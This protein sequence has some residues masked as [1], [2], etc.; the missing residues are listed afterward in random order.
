[1]VSPSLAWDAMLKYTGV[2]LNQ[3]VDGDID[4]LLMFEARIR[5]G[6]SYVGKRYAKANNKYMG[7][8]Y[9]PKDP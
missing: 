9:D 3:L 7:D 1:M 2:T 8:K 4:M 6:V 5:G